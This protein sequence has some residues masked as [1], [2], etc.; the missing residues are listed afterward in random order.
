MA[1]AFL[2]GPFDFLPLAHRLR[3]F[4]MEMKTI[5]I[6]DDEE[7]ILSI[8]E[9]S[10]ENKNF[11]VLTASSMKQGW[12]ILTQTEVDVVIT[13][14]QMPGESGFLLLQKAQNELQRRIPFIF[15]TGNTNLDP[16]EAHAQGATA[17]LF[18]P[19]DIAELLTLTEKAAMNQ[20]LTPLFFASPPDFCSSES[21]ARSEED[22]PFSSSP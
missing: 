4:V 17:I 18:K 2:R 11:K 7:D 15:L 6:I 1:P 19:F 9:F 12:E 8:L 16:A 14:I 3:N 13:D 5:L 21:D 20:E 22:V 10:F